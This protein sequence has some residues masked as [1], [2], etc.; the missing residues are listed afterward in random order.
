[1]LESRLAYN[2]GPLPPPSSIRLRPLLKIKRIAPNQIDSPAQKLD[3]HGE[4]IPKK[5]VRFTWEQQK[6]INKSMEVMGTDSPCAC[7]SPLQLRSMHSTAWNRQILGDGDESHEMGSRV[8]R[9]REKEGRER[10][11][12]REVK[13]TGEPLET[14][15]WAREADSLTWWV[16]SSPACW[17]LSGGSSRPARL[18]AAPARAP[19][20]PAVCVPREGGDPLLLADPGKAAVSS[21]REQGRRPG[22][23]FLL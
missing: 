17:P 7:S 20:P 14:D 9:E 6:Y 8:E 5:S 13:W 23:S 19:S 3:H 12:E 4:K 1:M 10:E 16:E 15:W 11:R 22:S 18:D 21:S 2:R